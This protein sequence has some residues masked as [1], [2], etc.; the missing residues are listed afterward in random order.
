M[1][2]KEALLFLKKKKQKDF[3]ESGPRELKNPG[4]KITKVFCAA[5]LQKSCRLLE[6]SL[7]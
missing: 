2:K 3:Y 5:F 7:I 1:E 6:L 4:S